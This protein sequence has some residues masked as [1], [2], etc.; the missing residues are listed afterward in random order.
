M[1]TQAD[2]KLLLRKAILKSIP[3][4]AAQFDEV[5]A[6]YVYVP[7]AHLRALE[8]DAMLVIGARGAGKSFWWRALQEE[9]LRRLVIKKS[10]SVSLGFGEAN[11]E[12]WPTKDELD[13][14]LRQDFSPRLV[15]KTV[16]LVQ[17]V[18]SLFSTQDWA[19]RVRW[20]TDH[21][22]EVAHSLRSYDKELLAQ[23]TTHLVL[24]DALDRTADSFSTRTSLLK[25]LLEL[26]LELRSYARLRAKVFVRPDMIAD[27]A[28]RAF[29]DASKVIASAV[30][31]E[32][33]GV[34]LYGLLFNYL[35]NGE[36]EA[37]AAEFRKIVGETKIQGGHWSVPQR[38]RVNELEQEKVFVAVA[39]WYMGT[40]QRRGKTYTWV[41]N[42]LA[43]SANRVSPRSFLVAIRRAA[44]ERVPDGH[45]FALHWTGL[46]EGVRQASQYRVREIEE[47]LPWVHKAM[48]LLTDLVVPC[49]K[50]RVFAAWRKGGLV[51]SGLQRTPET[52]DGVLEELIRMGI[53][54]VL[55]EGR[56]NIPD[57]YRVGF[58]L[59]RMGG[60]PP[61]I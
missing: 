45:Q 46:Q 58:G 13:L 43:D 2:R 48:E 32:W 20:V 33:R 21:P 17:I 36:E 34:D 26:V 40:N 47:D 9:I 14:L 5:S 51:E 42:H 11:N 7:A 18:P 3:P 6:K 27:T 4:V 54:S 37:S 24:F 56:I 44:E 12:Q 30:H 31:L 16:L 25:G 39:G 59:R 8:P 41:R 22:S 50:T 52:L 55:S 23:D 10:T 19:S 35:G 28:V 53:F 61:R 38:L 57:V 49:L 60:L 15:W 1:P 29:T